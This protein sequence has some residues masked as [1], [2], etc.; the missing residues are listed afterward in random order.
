[1]LFQ[2]ISW[3]TASPIYRHQE[4]FQFVAREKA[5]KRRGRQGSEPKKEYERRVAAMAW[6]R[7]IRVT[8]WR[9][10]TMPEVAVEKHAA[11]LA[12]CYA[13]GKDGGE[14]PEWVQDMYKAMR[15]Y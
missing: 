12:K 11:N 8:Y 14:A 4:W 15:R 9:D 13:P 3:L 6:R 2:S 5:R 7:I 1:M 10:I